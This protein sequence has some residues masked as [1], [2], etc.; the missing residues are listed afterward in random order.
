VLTS[1]YHPQTWRLLITP[2]APGAWNM[3][4]DE[5]ILEAVEQNL[6]PATLRLYAW[7]PPCLSIGY[8]QP[9]TDIDFN[10]L[11]SEGWD[12]VRRPT[13][14]RAILHTDEFTYSVIA[15]QSDPRVSGGVLESYRRLS[16]ALL[17][18]LHNMNIPAESQQ[19][20]QVERNQGDAAVCF[21]VPSN[22]E[23]VVKG[24]KLIGSAQARRKNAVLQHGTFPLWGDLIRITQVLA[25]SND[26]ERDTAATRL[27]SH[28]TT[29]ERILGEK[30]DWD[31]VVTAFISGF[32]SELNLQLIPGSTSDQEIM[33]TKLLIQEKY[34]H[35]SWLNRI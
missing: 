32:Q 5:A 18:A 21:E 33:R 3:A 30:L 22:Y 6:A 23:I 19:N 34:Q 2:A 12:W 8:A 35:M 29:A 16:T 7:D 20:N 24:K 27:L 1:H 10:R 11:E 28:A 25:F 31:T 26:Q 14:G 13:G 9:S 17:K 4:L 15:P